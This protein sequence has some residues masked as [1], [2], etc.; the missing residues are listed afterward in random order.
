MEKEEDEAAEEEKAEA[1]SPIQVVF[2]S[3]FCVVKFV[4]D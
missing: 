4:K 3:R 2:L 1:E